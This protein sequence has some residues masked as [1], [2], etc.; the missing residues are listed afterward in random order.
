MKLSSDMSMGTLLSLIGRKVRCIKE[1]STGFNKNTL[2]IGQIYTVRNAY[3]SIM[4]IPCFVVDNNGIYGYTIEH[5]ELIPG[6]LYNT[7]GNV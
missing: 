1:P 4:D 6:K 2:T 7:G 5:F 3:K